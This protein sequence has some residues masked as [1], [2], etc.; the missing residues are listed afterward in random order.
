[1]LVL[2]HIQDVLQGDIAFLDVNAI[3][4]SEFVAQ[5][6]LLGRRNRLRLLEQGQSQVDEAVAVILDL[7]HRSGLEELIERNIIRDVI[8]D[9]S[10]QVFSV[11]SIVTK[12]QQTINQKE[13]SKI[14]FHE[15]KLCPKINFRVS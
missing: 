11:G 8:L 9:D 3:P 12:V 7:L 4:Q 13:F 6:L 2:E 14:L 10:L 15:P 1:M 5:E